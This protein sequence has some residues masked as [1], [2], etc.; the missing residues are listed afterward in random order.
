M[1][2][3]V[4]FTDSTSETVDCYRTR[5]EDGI[6]RLRTTHDT[7]YDERWDSYPLANIRNWKQVDR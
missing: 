4:T 2:I 5:V 7:A 1:K 3:K 6:L